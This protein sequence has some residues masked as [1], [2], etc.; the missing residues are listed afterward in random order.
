MI[1][2]DLGPGETY[3]VPALPGYSGPI[4]VLMGDEGGLRGE[5]ALSAVTLKL[6]P[7][8]R[9]LRRRIWREAFRGHRV[10]GMDAI[11]DQFLL[12]GGHIRQVAKMAA[13]RA[14]LEGH[15]SISLI[16]VRH[17]SRALNRQSLDTLATRLEA[18]GAWKELALSSE[19]RAKLEEMEQRCRH[20][21]SLQEQV[22]GRGVRALFSG[23]SGTGKTMAAK[24]LAASLGMD[25]Y[26]VD[27]A[28]VVNKYIGETEKNLHQ[29]LSR[30]EELDV[31]LLL[32]EGDALMA[33]RTDVRSAND[34]YANLETNYLLQ[35]LEHYQGIVIITTNAGDLIDQGFRRRL[36]VVVTFVPPGAPERLLIWKLHLPKDHQVP[37]PYLADV[38]ARCA[39]TGG[40]IKSAATHGALLA[41]DQGSA[42]TQQILADAILSEYRKAGA[43][44]PLTVRPGGAARQSGLDTFVQAMRDK[45]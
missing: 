20:R 24:I 2:C 6:P 16:D 34:R 1:R 14:A 28:A 11:T 38:A 13:A 19:T 36:D 22:Q 29:V 27:L 21:E 45:R 10:Y 7:L 5:A 15:K 17:A 39:L 42:F 23:P 43:L 3:E 40:Q 33:R 32:D 12:P 37:A 44:C 18:E 4:L 25:I 9:T 31:I 8:D 41:V 30:A 35:R 26:R